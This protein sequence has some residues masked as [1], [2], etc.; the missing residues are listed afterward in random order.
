MWQGHHEG[1]R[2]PSPAPT[3]G[4][5]PTPNPPFQQLRAPWLH[6]VELMPQRHPQPWRSPAAAWWGGVKGQ[7]GWGAGRLPHHEPPPIGISDRVCIKAL[8][9]HVHPRLQGAIFFALSSIH[10]SPPL[11]PIKQVFAEPILLDPEVLAGNRTDPASA[12]TELTASGACDKPNPGHRGLGTALSTVPQPPD[13][14]IYQHSHF[15]PCFSR[16]L[17][18]CPQGLWWSWPES[19][20]HLHVAHTQEPPESGSIKGWALPSAEQCPPHFGQRRGRCTWQLSLG[21]HVSTP[22]SPLLGLKD[23]SPAYLLATIP[24]GSAGMAHPIAHLTFPCLLP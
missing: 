22:I 13:L 17:V 4:G 24:P 21:K 12:F 7:M 23:K 10:S 9:K 18:L 2:E 20:P 15:L 14:Q 11:P 6:S 19:P 3:H 8:T 16:P 5:L 1:I